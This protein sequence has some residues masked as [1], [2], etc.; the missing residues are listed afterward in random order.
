MK[1]NKNSKTS[2]EWTGHT[3]LK[4]Q[5]GPCKPLSQE[6]DTMLGNHTMKIIS[7]TCKKGDEL[8][9]HSFFLSWSQLLNNFTIEKK[10]RYK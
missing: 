10:I 9:I 4:Q 7:I 2:T 1:R 6:G 5:E 3:K 8:Y